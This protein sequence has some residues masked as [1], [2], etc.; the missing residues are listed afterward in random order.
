MTDTTDQSFEVDVVERSRTV[1]VVVDFWAEWCG[2]CRQLTPVLEAAVAATE[3]AIELV[4][5]DVDANPRVSA[6]HRVQS[7]PVV[8]AYRDGRVVDEFVGALPRASV[9]SFLRGLLPS[10]A[11]Q[12]VEKG[13]EESLR[14]AL[15]LEPNHPGAL[16]ALARLQSAADPVLG[17]GVAAIE[18]GQTERGLDL[19]LDALQ[20]ASPDLRDRIRKLMVGVFTQLGQDHPVSAEYRRRLSAALY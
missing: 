10:E 14:R 12:L 9:D 6:A 7:I 19:L 3:G 18:A 8:K 13:D 16:G 17:P 11:D 2:P 5:V 15:E 4:K 1:P 20:G